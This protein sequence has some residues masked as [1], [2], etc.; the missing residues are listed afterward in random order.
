MNLVKNCKRRYISLNDQCETHN[1][2]SSQDKVLWIPLRCLKVVFLKSLWKDDSSDIYFCLSSFCGSSALKSSILRCCDNLNLTLPLPLK[3][4]PNPLLSA[5]QGIKSELRSFLSNETWTVDLSD[6]R[7]E[8]YFS[9]LV[10]I[11]FGTPS[12]PSILNVEFLS[13]YITHIL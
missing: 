11:L 9:K 6:F 2:V 1:C 3:W 8:L 12:R 5:Y 7:A 4:K 10:H 13:K